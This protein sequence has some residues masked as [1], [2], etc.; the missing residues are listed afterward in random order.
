MNVEKAKQWIEMYINLTDGEFR[1]RIHT[2]EGIL[3]LPNDIFICLLSGGAIESITQDRAGY[4]FNGDFGRTFIT[5]AP[6]DSEKRRNS[7]TL[8]VV[9]HERQKKNIVIYANRFGLSEAQRFCDLPDFLKDQLLSLP[10]SAIV[11]PLIISDI[12][13]GSPNVAKIA[14]RY[15]VAY[16]TVY[17]W[18]YGA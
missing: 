1:Q 5:V 12:S 8:R 3:I 16:R 4:Y 17:K 6:F 18:I 11:R 14:V 15:G 13:G 10:Y 7:V 2:G 9:D